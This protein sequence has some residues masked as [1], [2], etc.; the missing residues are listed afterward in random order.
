MVKVKVKAM[1]MVKVKVMVKVNTN[2]KGKGHGKGKG[3]GFKGNG[4]NR[5]QFIKT[6]WETVPTPCGRI[7][8][9]TFVLY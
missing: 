7:L 1:V 9:D 6:H 8:H 5:S 3:Q 2:G 4:L